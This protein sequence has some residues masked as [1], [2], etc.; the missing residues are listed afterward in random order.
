[1]S[2]ALL[3]VALLAA[4]LV[5][6]AAQAQKT[7]GISTGKF[8]FS[9]AA[10]Q[11]G[12]GNL[13]VLND[14]D[15]PIQVLVY[16]ANQIV[17]ETGEITYQIP[18]RDNPGIGFDPASW[19]SIS[20]PTSNRTVGNTPVIELNP[21]ENAPVDFSLVVPETVPPG[22]HQII[23]FFEMLGEDASGQTGAQIVGRLGARIRVRVQGEIIDRLEV[24]PFLLRS[25][26]IGEAA[27]YTFV[28][29]NGGNIDKQVG[30]HLLMLDGDGNEVSSST[31]VTETV[32]YAG[33]NAEYQ[34]VANPGVSL[35]KYTARLVV[36]Y[37]REAEN[38]ASL[39]DQVIAEQS[40]WVFPLWLV[41]AAIVG[42][43]LALVYWSWRQAV[44]SSHKRAE[45]QRARRIARR[46][47]ARAAAE[48]INGPPE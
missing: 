32:V 15:E 22:D 39:P 14:G 35:G 47:A 27:P 6:S 48:S 29:R 30:V 46:E 37:E 23:L 11:G 20:T 2:R 24:R 42:L 1:M 45:E 34:G 12:S 31:L 18:S 25:L 4:M 19:V 7:I 28:M 26:I 8:E 13:L 10:G 16:S 3:L 33:S 40:V 5:P 17:D 21:G 38:G 44:K 43:G 41:I 36:D 9:L